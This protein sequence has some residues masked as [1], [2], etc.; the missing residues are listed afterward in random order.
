MN[1][2]ALSLLWQAT[3]ET[4]LMVGA[5]TV[6]AVLGVCPGYPS[7]GNRTRRHFGKGLAEPH[8]GR[9]GQPGP[10]RTFHHPHG[11]HYSLHPPD[12]GHLH[13]D[14]G[15]HC[16]PHGGSHPFLARLVEGALKEVDP[17]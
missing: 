14:H 4:L 3:Q 9:R 12:C 5:A 7:G 10:F 6:L 15:S 8:P 17:G 2:A 1:Q 16:A 13:R 11:G